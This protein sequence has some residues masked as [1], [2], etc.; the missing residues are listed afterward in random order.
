LL[1]KSSAELAVLQ[2]ALRRDLSCDLRPEEAWEIEPRDAAQSGVLR[3]SDRLTAP[4][5]AH[6]EHLLAVEQ[7]ERY[8]SLK[9]HPE[10]IHG[11]GFPQQ[12]VTVAPPVQVRALQADRA[13]SVGQAHHGLDHNASSGRFRWIGAGAQRLQA[14]D[15]IGAIPRHVG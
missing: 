2:A 8:V 7:I 12:T 11:G 10:L 6:I 15:G 4:S 3:V 5:A 14:L 1:C 9:G 13:A